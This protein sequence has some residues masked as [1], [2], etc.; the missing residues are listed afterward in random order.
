MFAEQGYVVV[1]PNLTGSLGYGQEFIEAIYHNW[2]GSACL[3]LAHCFEQLKGVP[4]I[5]CT[6]SIALG[7]SYGDL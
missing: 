7:G 5:D 3:E 4:Y 6:R 1:M 2:R